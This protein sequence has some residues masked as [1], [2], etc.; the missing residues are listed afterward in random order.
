VHALSGQR[1]LSVF[2]LG[3]FNIGGR[4]VQQRGKNLPQARM[5]DGEPVGMCN[6]MEARRARAFRGRQDG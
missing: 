1:R 3:K 2:T 6:G 4:A 5:R